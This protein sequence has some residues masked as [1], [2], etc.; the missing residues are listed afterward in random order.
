[1]NDIFQSATEPKGP[2]PNSEPFFFFCRGKENKLKED[3]KAVI[4]PALSS[5]WPQPCSPQSVGLY[6]Y[7]AGTFLGQD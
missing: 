1:M 2:V 6:I 3:R 7:S 4:Q 5:P